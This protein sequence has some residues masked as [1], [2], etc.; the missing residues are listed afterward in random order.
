MWTGNANNI[1]FSVSSAF[2]NFTY[3]SDGWEANESNR[4]YPGSRNIEAHT[5]TAAA[6]A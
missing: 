1:Q 6:A 2:Q 3:L 5:G 4:G